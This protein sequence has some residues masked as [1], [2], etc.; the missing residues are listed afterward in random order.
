MPLVSGYLMNPSGPCVATGGHTTRFHS[1]SAVNCS[2]TVIGSTQTDVYGHY[3]ILLYRGKYRI[4][5]LNP[6]GQQCCFAT[7][8]P[9]NVGTFALTVNIYAT[10]VICQGSSKA[11]RAYLYDPR[12]C[13]GPRRTFCGSS[14]AS[15]KPSTT[16]SSSP[17]SASAMT[18]SRVRGKASASPSGTRAISARPK[19]S[20]PRF[21]SPKPGKADAAVAASR[22][23]VTERSQGP[24][25]TSG[26]C[27]CASPGGPFSC[28]PYSSTLSSHPSSRPRR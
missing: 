11:M 17:V 21:S 8:D 1:A 14:A 24:G 16:G 9:L 22:P 10:C 6:N 13:R 26:L 25:D 12:G 7:P 3:S 27:S 4:S 2:S 23:S 19:N 5:V 18:T 28:S 20:A 15:I